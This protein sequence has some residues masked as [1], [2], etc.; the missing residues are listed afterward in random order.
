MQESAEIRRSYVIKAEELAALNF[1]PPDPPRPREVEW[2]NRGTDQKLR[3]STIDMLMRT[4][5][6]EADTPSVVKLR[7]SAGLRATFAS[8]TD[9]DRFATA[10]RNAMAEERENKEHLVTAVFNDREGADCAVKELVEAGVPEAAIVVLGRL[11]EFIDND[12]AP[13]QG[14]STLSV[15]GAVSASGVAGALLGIAVMAIPGVGP[16]AAA[17]ALAASAYS[18]VAAV[19]GVIGATG[20][21]IA[22]MLSDADVDDVALNYREQQLRRGRIFVAV[23]TRAA[24]GYADTARRVMRECEGRMVAEA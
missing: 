11:S 12:D 4:L 16:V 23:D 3:P 19:S 18:S 24:E 1:L 7:Q 15:A 5:Y 20:G 6:R 2:I 14:A 9:R 8:I 13:V 21:A 10:F 22:R 17:G